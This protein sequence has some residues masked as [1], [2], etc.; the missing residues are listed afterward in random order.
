MQ[1]LSSTAREPL[2]NLSNSNTP[3]GPFQM[4][5]LAFSMTAQ[6]EAMLCS[7]I[8]SPSQSAGIP[9]LTV[10]VLVYTDVQQHTKK[11]MFWLGGLYQVCEYSYEQGNTIAWSTEQVVSDGLS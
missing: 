9:E 3:S 1:M 8:S 4:M 6:K 5:V 7:P 10:A 2:E 11:N